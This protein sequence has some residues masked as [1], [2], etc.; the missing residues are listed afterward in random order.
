[1]I[2][3]PVVGESLVSLWLHVA[4]VGNAFFYR[5]AI[6]DQ[7]KSTGDMTQRRCNNNNPNQNSVTTL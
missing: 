4:F 5:C 3:E 7:A 2:V 6:E 1:M